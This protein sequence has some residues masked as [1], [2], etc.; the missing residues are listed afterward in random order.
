VFSLFYRNT[1]LL[2]LTICLIVVWGLSSF[3]T[4]PRMEDPEL[5]QRAALVIT[6]LPGASA[7]RVESLVTEKIER[8]LF[9]IKE[10]DTVASTS[11]LGIST[12][13]VR[14]KEEVKKV[15]EVWS[16][17][18]DKLSGVRPELPREAIEPQFR[19]LEVR[20]SALIV[21][22]NWE[23][24][25][26]PNAA[27]LRRTA[28]ELEDQLRFVAG[29]EKVEF[30]GDPD[31][32]IT[33]EVSPAELTAR[34]LTAA[35]LSRQIQASDAKVA[36]GQLRGQDNTLLFEV[37]GELDSLERIRRIPIQLGS[38][39]QVA[40]LGD[41]ARVE[42]GIVDPPTELAL[43]NGHPAIA[44]SV[45]I[46]SQERLDGWAQ[47]AKAKLVQF[48]Q[49]LPRGIGLHII[50]DQSRYVDARLRTV[51]QELI[52]GCL[53]V[54]IVSF[55]LMGWK[56][57]LIVG[58]ALPLA[59]LMVFGGMKLMGV[60]LHQIS[61]SGIII[62]LGLL[63]DNAI[64]IV[65]EVQIRLEDGM[66]PAQAVA[67][68]VQ[69][70][71]LPLISSTVATVL[72][73]LPIAIAPGGVGEFTGSIGVTGI[74]GIVSS[75]LL[76]LTVLPA[77][78]G[79][80]HRWRHNPDASAWWQVGFSHPRLSRFYRWTL[81]RT[82]SRPMVGVSLALILPVLGFALAPHLGLQ[83]F[84]PTDRDQFYIEMELPTPSSLAQTQATVMKARKVIQQYPEIREVSW[85]VGKSAPKF[86]YNVIDSRENS[87]NFAQ[88]LV[89]LQSNQGMRQTIRRLQTELDQTFPSAQVLVRQLEQGPPFD[90]P[91]EIRLYGADVERLRELGNQ[92]RT[93]LAQVPGIVHTRA[94]L[95]EALLKLGISVDEEQA[96]IAGLNNT[97]IAQQLDTNL[98]GSLGGS[99]L[100]GTEEIPVRVRLSNE[101]R[102]NLAQITS[103]DLLPNRGTATT[104][105]TVPLSAV[106]NIEL[107]P[108]LA[109]ITH[110]N[111]ERVNTVQGFIQA[112]LLPAT[113]L[114]QFNQRLKESGFT[115]PSGYTLE[116]GG[117]QDTRRRAVGNLLSTV[118]VLLV[119]MVATL[120]LT[121]NSFQL[122]GLIGIIVILSCGL[123]LGALW[124][125]G[126]PF[127]F[128][129][130]LGLI[131]LIGIAVNESIVVLTAIQED[132]DA[133]QGNY[134]AT[135]EVVVRS[136]R[137]MIT[138]TLT[139][140]IGFV[141]LLFD[142]TGFW[143]PLAIVIA[144]GL[145]GV[146]LLSLYFLPAA[147]LLLEWRKN[148]RGNISARSAGS[149]SAVL[150]GQN[151]S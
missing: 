80:I 93:I 128:T 107:V 100:E 8:E 90:A 132:A 10:I 84:P 135:T 68:S 11:R 109:T 118:G 4:L 136:T 50:L 105:Q 70:M 130:M 15:D 6:R 79:R 112:G 25:S 98:E 101:Q 137:H 110:R 13:T 18:R 29:T 57:A 34:G 88:G 95:T 72:G 142:R 144:G 125:S 104:T 40:L 127:G 75:L 47:I 138:T 17:I 60:P 64:V 86:F 139:D 99:I 7:E 143:P 134:Q 123:G 67:D 147:Y 146:T 96:R 27:V 55:I 121:F 114:K 94:N 77:L 97:T 129:A 115:L 89:Q 24:D 120:V 66:T 1:Q 140:S 71:T 2:L 21:A 43:V 131:G 150:L 14:L 63:I 52:L 85:F 126:Y 81:T 23:L 22:L 59:N 16:R 46:E 54:T 141:P 19:D 61:V 38:R 51:Y 49:Q 44:L 53:M 48:R 151:S 69:Q 91:V 73:F 124:L 119:L 20:A 42:K 145:G 30:V 83:F 74:L 5:T 65:D 133:K 56:S 35:E 102:G 36:A 28:E 117:E 103:L 45:V 39:G 148:P 12:I 149:S 62:A 58:S 122:A 33:V 37:K 116:Y 78:A 76:S 3:L 87:P 31:E 9:S 113:V 26:P 106:G 32:E 111:G 82:F 41:I 92:M 108:D